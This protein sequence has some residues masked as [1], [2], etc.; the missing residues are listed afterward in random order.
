MNRR[1]ELVRPAE[2][3]PKVFREREVQAR[4]PLVDGLAWLP[5]IAQLISNLPCLIVDNQTIFVWESELISYG[6][7]WIEFSARFI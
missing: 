1:G 5:L 4:P 3:R 2:T 7:F 6:F